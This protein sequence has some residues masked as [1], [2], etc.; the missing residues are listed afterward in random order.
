MAKDIPGDFKTLSPFML[1]SLLGDIAVTSQQI[2]CLSGQAEDALHGD[3]HTVGM[4][5]AA[6][7]SLAQRAGWIADTAIADYGSN[8]PLVGDAVEWMLPGLAGAIKGKS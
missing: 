7:V 8:I 4:L 6:I 2:A 3:T 1:V 5:L